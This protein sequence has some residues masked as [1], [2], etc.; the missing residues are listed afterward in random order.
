M[1]IAI[2]TKGKIAPGGGQ[3]TL[4][5]DPALDVELLEEIIV[6]IIDDEFSVEMDEFTVELEPLDDLD[7]ESNQ[8]N[9]DIE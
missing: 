3:V 8:F 4:V 2:V 6:Q 9:V 1:T 7:I 5:G